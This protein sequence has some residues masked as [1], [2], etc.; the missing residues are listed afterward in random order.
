MAYRL[1]WSP[2][3]LTD[4]EAIAQYIEQDSLSYAR[5]VVSKIV[6][7]TRQIEQFPMAGRIVPE[8]RDQ[9]IRELFVFSYRVIYQIEVDLVTV[10]AV[11]HGKRLLE[12]AD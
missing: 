2:Q 6:A 4:V 12:T 5:A 10:V 9:A 7:A 11:V 1:V 8:M 3:A